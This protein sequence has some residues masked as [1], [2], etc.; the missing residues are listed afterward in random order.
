MRDS[1]DNHHADSVT[2]ITD[3]TFHDFMVPTS[4]EILSAHAQGKTHLNS[5][6]DIFLNSELRPNNLFAS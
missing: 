5:H 4:L 2:V 1:R 6:L 3:S